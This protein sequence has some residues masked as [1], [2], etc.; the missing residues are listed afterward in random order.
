MLQTRQSHAKS[1]NPNF[2]SASLKK[3]E[4]NLDW[5]ERHL[6]DNDDWTPMVLVGG[7]GTTAFRLRSAQSVARHDLTPSHWSHVMFLGRTSIRTTTPT[8]EIALDPDGGFGF[9]PESNAVQKGKLKQYRDPA[10]YPNIA[11]AALPVSFKE[12]KR[13][14]ESFQRQRGVFDAVELTVGWLAY[15]WGLGGGRVPFYDELG[16]PC[17]AF[18]ETVLAAAGFEITPGLESRGSCPEAIWQALRWWHNYY[19]DDDTGAESLQGAPRGAFSVTH[20]LPD[21]P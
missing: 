12:V 13:G 2:V 3:G 5:L 11:V 15:T 8:L 19:Q 18:V 17:A 1:A 16:M 20:E 4:D 7:K 14:I 21:A 6:P 10:E 9:P